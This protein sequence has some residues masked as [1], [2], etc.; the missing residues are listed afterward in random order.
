MI[1]EMGKSN[2]ASTFGNFP[3]VWNCQASNDGLVSQAP[4]VGVTNHFHIA[5]KNWGSIMPRM[6]R[7]P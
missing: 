5:V 1:E 7:S 6:S 3:V 2:Y 4:V